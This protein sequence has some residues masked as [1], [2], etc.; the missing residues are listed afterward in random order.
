MSED[1]SIEELREQKLEKLRSRVQDDEQVSAEQPDTA[2]TPTSPVT[3]NGANDLAETTSQ[4][5]VVIADFYADWCG[6]CKMIAPVLEEIAAETDAAVA[7]VDIDQHQGLAGE[8]GV[9][10]VP[11]LIVF[12]NGEPVDRMVGMQ[13]K[14]TIMRA[15]SKHG[16]A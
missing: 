5:D 2:T 7:K 13:E 3:I 8:Y 1:Q 9:R 11:T 15:L 14:Q 6:P 10:G 12:A 16:A 4:Y